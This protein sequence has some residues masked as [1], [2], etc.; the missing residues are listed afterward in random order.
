MHYL[1]H[2]I[3]DCLVKKIFTGWIVIKLYK[4]KVEFWEEMKNNLWA[5]SWYYASV[6]EHW[7]KKCSLKSMALL[8][9]A[10][11]IIK[12]RTAFYATCSCSP[13][14]IFLCTVLVSLPRL[15]QILIILMIPEPYSK[16]QY[17]YA[18]RSIFSDWF[19]NVSFTLQSH[20]QNSTLSLSR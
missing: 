11:N 5:L 15:G 9:M 7:I 18:T 16:H 13:I 17:L 19:H 14:Y 20:D 12:I 8:N 6:E 3:H 4:E 2:Y 1:I 10:Y